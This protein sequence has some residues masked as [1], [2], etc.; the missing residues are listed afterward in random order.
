MLQLESAKASGSRAGAHF[1]HPKDILVYDS[2]NKNELLAIATIVFG[3]V[4]TLGS[5][6]RNRFA[7][8]EDRE[9]QNLQSH[10]SDSAVGSHRPGIACL[11]S[12]T[13]G[14][15]FGNLSRR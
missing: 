11:M 3:N 15:V 14:I 1:E 4:V 6:R 5:A 2:D 10:A 12:Q 13:A 9:L 8:A 7:T